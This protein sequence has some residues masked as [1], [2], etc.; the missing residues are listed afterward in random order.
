MYTTYLNCGSVVVQTVT[1]LGVPVEVGVHRVPD[2]ELRSQDPGDRVDP[3]GSRTG[4]VRDPDP[5]GRE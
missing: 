5:E 3:G 2:V 1:H 4:G